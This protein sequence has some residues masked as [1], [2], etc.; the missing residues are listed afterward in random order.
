MCVAI[1]GKIIEIY[2]YESLI[3]FGNIKKRINTFFI[4]DI[5]IG[6]YVLVHAGSAIEKISEQEALETLELF[7]IIS[8]EL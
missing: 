5:K 8:N 1:P 7:K 2:E 6:E 4:D 3:D